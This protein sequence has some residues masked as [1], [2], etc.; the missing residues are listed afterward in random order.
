MQTLWE[1]VENINDNV[2]TI[3]GGETGTTVSTTVTGVSSSATSVTLADENTDRA[4][5]MIYNASAYTLYITYG[6]TASIASGGY[7]MAIESNG[8]WEMPK[9]VDTGV[10]SGI[11][12]NVDGYANI[13]ESEYA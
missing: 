8:Y 2:A 6:A 9:P 3:S 1:L 5:L 11:W 12:S 4:N 10:I 7:V 13:T